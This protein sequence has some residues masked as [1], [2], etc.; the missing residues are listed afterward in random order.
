[1]SESSGAMLQCLW[2]AA[3]W[4]GLLAPMLTFELPD[5]PMSLCHLNK[6]FLSIMVSQVVTGGHYDVDCRL[7]TQMEITQYKEMKKQYDSFTFTA[8]RMAPTIIISSHSLNIL[9]WS[10]TSFFFYIYFLLFLFTISDESAVCPFHEALKSCI[11][12]TTH[13]PLPDAQGR[14]L[15]RGPQNNACAFW[16]I[17]R[18]LYPSGVSIS[19]VVLLRKN[20]SKDGSI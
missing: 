15:G 17:G 10:C 6:W 2:P 4:V 7:E 20:G 14:S 3:L 5:T 18:S 16:S 12:Y 9:H 13:F 1:M 11:D 19:Q 8:S